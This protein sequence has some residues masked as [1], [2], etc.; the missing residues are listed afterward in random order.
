M[1]VLES[2][3]SAIAQLE[4]MRRHGD[5]VPQLEQVHEAI[6]ELIEI[7][8]RP[9]QEVLGNKRRKEGY[10]QME[11]MYRQPGFIPLS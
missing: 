10:R 7:G 5:E 9:V 1:T 2:L 4:W 11:E 3:L 8:G 6:V